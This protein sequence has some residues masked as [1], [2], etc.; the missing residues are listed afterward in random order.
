MADIRKPTRWFVC[1]KPKPQATLRL[2]CFPYAGGGISIYRAWPDGLPANIEV[3]SVK[4]PGRGDRLREPLIT[5]FEPLV[6]YLAQ[7]FLPYTDK[8]FA[9]F[10]HSMGALICYELTRHLR[11]EHG[12]MPIHLFVSGRNAPQMPLMRCP[13]YDL[14][15]PEFIEELRRLEGMPE[16]ILQHREL[17]EMVQPILRA[18]MELVETYAYAH[19]PP[20]DCPI[21]AFGGLQ[22]HLLRLDGLEAWRDQTTAPFKLCMFSGN[23]F[24][25][26][27]AQQ[28]LLTAI[29]R[30]LYLDCSGKVSA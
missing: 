11:K 2:F 8:P 10:G 27:T 28:Q 5:R 23:H 13:I 14:P 19:E 6:E 4:L 16:E 9:F 29:S 18:D 20:L 26:H 12:L 1:V 17:M 7:A 22:D 21:S 25:I 3:C 24:F 30:D 15:Q